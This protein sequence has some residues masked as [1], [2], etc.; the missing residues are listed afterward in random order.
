VLLFNGYKVSVLLDYGPN[1]VV[2]LLLSMH[3]TLDFILTTLNV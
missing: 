2:E 1:S 3:E